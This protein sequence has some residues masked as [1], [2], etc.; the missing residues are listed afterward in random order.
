MA[1]GSDPG[2]P[3]ISQAHRHLDNDPGK[4]N[5]VLLRSQGCLKSSPLGFLLTLAKAERGRRRPVLC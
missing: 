5:K 2:E 4:R 3:Q 1:V